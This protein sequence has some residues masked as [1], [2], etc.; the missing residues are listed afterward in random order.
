MTNLAYLIVTVATAQAPD[1]PS[2]GTRVSNLTEDT[3]CIG[4]QLSVQDLRSLNDEVGDN[5]NTK[6]VR[7]LRRIRTVRVI[8]ASRQLQ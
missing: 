2:P 5:N 6:A 8:V 4:D 3:Q 1:S 7:T